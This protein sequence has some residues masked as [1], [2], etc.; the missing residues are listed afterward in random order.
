MIRNAMEE[1]RSLMAMC[2]IELTIARSGPR[3]VHR[4]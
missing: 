2:L 3:T 1:L 4:P